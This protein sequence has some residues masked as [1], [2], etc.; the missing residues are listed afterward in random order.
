[1]PKLLNISKNYQ[2][3]NQSQGPAAGGS[4]LEDNIYYKKLSVSKPSFLFVFSRLSVAR[5]SVKPWFETGVKVERGR[6]AICPSML[7]ESSLSVLR[8][9]CLNHKRNHNKNYSVCNLDDAFPSGFQFDSIGRFALQSDP[10]CQPFSG[11]KTHLR[12]W[13]ESLRKRW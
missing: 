7:P 8:C 5:G 12:N 2:S 13:L 6:A 1:V 9:S 4:A 10:I 11:P 3:T